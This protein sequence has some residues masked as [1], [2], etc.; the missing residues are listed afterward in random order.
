MTRRGVQLPLALCTVAALAATGSAASAQQV[1]LQWK[2]VDGS[3]L[4]Y[5]MRNYQEMEMPE[6]PGGSV[7]EQ[8]QTMR[9][10]V[11]EVA[12]NGDATMRITT[13]RIQV[14][15]EGPMGNVAYDSATDEAPTNPMAQ[16]FAAMAGLSYTLVIGSDGTV[17]SVQGIEEVR[18][19]IFSALPPEVSAMA[20]GMLDQMFTEETMTSMMQQSI[21]V[22]PQEPVGPGDSWQ[23]SFGFRLP[24]IG[25]MTTNLD[26]TVD[27]IEERDG[28]TVAVISTT[29]EM[30]FGDDPDSQLAGMMAIGNTAMIGSFV[31]DVDRGITLESNTSMTMEMTVAAGGQEMVMGMVQTTTLELIE[32]VSEH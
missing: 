13:E 9:W 19:A 17:K 31:F 24:M 18:D 29:G 22:F 21:H 26:F 28:R 25:T 27:A 32:Y 30:T 8:T 7:S 20:Q 10:S 16:I 11:L 2:Y 5:R 14:N 6:G 1:T 3:E 23:N 12:P 15:M 4:V